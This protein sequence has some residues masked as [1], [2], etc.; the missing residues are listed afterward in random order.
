[1]SLR[2]LNDRQLLSATEILVRTERE[3]LLSVLHHLQEID[4]RKLYSALKFK[5]LF[6]YVVQKLGYSEDQAC[7]R[8][9]AMRMLK[10]FSP[11]VC[12]RIESKINDG[13]LCLTHLNMAQ[14]FFKKEEAILSQKISSEKKLEVLE[15]IENTSTREAEKIVIG[16]SSA[17][18]QIPPEKLRP[19]TDELSELKT[20]LNK[21]QLAKIQKLK[22]L[23][24]HRNPN[25]EF[26]ELLDVLLDLG[27]EEFDPGQKVVRSY[28]SKIFNQKGHG[29]I[30]SK[31][32]QI[33]KSVNSHSENSP[34][35]Q[36]VPNKTD[37]DQVN[38]SA[39][40]PNENN[41][42][43]ATNVRLCKPTNPRFI[44]AKIRREVWR[45][46]QSQCANCKSTFTLE[47]DHIQPLALG[48]NSEIK[49]LSMTCRS[50]NQR[51]G[52][53]KLGAYVM[54][55]YIQAYLG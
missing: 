27:M 2:N 36:R 10:S 37:L 48:G 5:S 31:L 23:L 55:R 46:Y 19:I 4:R 30:K 41:E 20:V 26:T 35:A 44:S 51:A 53:N 24:A 8:I 42:S 25:M 54:D 40:N 49:N 32:I 38:S 14:N 13:A 18:I 17:P 16:L 28:Q 50:C 34:A 45:K 29:Q 9:S 7:R 11:E 52:R 47:I 15:K 12:E 6:D 21:E 33:N 39:K 43:P 3:I 22:G 1:M